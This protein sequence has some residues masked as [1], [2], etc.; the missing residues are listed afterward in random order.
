MFYILYC[1]KN[2]ILILSFAFTPKTRYTITIVA[3]RVGL[4]IGHTVK[5]QNGCPTDGIQ[6]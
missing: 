6:S 4:P 1:C 3:I 5:V 2:L